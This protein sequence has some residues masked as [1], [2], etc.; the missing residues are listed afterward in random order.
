MQV[1]DSQWTPCTG[2]VLSVQEESENEHD[3][4]A[5]GV[6]KSGTIIGHVPREVS[7]TFFLRHGGI[8]SCKITGHRKFGLGSTGGTMLL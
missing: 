8:I 4:Y 5:V 1:T 2:E 6:I 3:V 7:K